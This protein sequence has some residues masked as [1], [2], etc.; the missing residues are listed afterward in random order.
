MSEPRPC[1][2]SSDRSRPQIVSRGDIML[3]VC[4]PRGWPDRLIEQYASEVCPVG[5]DRRWRVPL[6]P[7][8]ER[9]PRQPC[10]YAVAPPAMDH[11]LL[12][13]WAEAAA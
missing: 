13:R 1:Y 9:V 10:G 11:L 5:D 12:V 3:V 4:V 6:G 2:N 7:R 8:G